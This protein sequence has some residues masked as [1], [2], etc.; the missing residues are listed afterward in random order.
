MDIDGPKRTALKYFFLGA[1]QWLFVTFLLRDAVRKRSLVGRC[2]FVAVVC[3]SVTF[4]YYPQTAEDVLKRL[5]SSFYIH[6]Y[7]NF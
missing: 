1:K 5:Q 6:T 2:P 4:V 7:I 3:L